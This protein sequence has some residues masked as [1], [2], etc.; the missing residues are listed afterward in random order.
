MEKIVRFNYCGDTTTIYSYR[1]WTIEKNSITRG[2]YIKPPQNF[3][4]HTWST[5]TLKNAK[6]GIDTVINSTGE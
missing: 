2:W 3:K 1:D 5:M 6:S 4:W